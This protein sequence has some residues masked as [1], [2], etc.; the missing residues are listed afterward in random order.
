MNDLQTFPTFLSTASD[1]AHRSLSPEPLQAAKGSYT[2]DSLPAAQEYNANARFDGTYDGNHRPYTATSSIYS[3]PN[4]P[5][6]EP[7]QVY[8]PYRPPQSP[9][10]RYTQMHRD[11]AARK[12]EG[13]NVEGESSMAAYTSDGDD[14][15]VKSEGSYDFATA[16]AHKVLEEKKALEAIKKGNTA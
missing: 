14:D 9:V 13:S 3:Q 8:Q 5:L 1:N 16:R 15:D 2:T 4:V 6:S 12:L 10:G 11:E 7:N